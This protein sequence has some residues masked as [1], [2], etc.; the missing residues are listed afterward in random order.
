MFQRVF[1]IR[2]FVALIIVKAMWLVALF[3]HCGNICW[4]VALSMIPMVTISSRLTRLDDIAG[5]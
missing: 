4:T 3:S 2:Y 1:Q 5:R